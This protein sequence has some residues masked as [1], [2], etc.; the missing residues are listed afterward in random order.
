[1][2]SSSSIEK[3][4][5]NSR[6]AERH[7]SPE[8]NEPDSGTEHEE[9]GHGIE[10]AEL[11]RIAFVALAAAAVWFQLWEPFRHISVIGIAATLIGGFPIFREAGEHRRTKDD[12][13]AVQ[14]A[15]PQP[16][17]RLRISDRYVCMTSCSLMPVIKKNS[18]QSR[19]S[20]S[21][22]AKSVSSSLSSYISGS[23][24][25]YRGQSFLPT[26]PRIPFAF[27]KDMTFE[28]LFQQLRGA[29]S[30]SSRRNAWYFNRSFRSISSRF[31]L[32]QDSV[33]YARAVEYAA[34]VFGFFVSLV[35]SR[36][37]A[38]AAATDL[39]P[40]WPSGTTA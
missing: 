23:S 8:Q 36:K 19:S 33:K 15:L 17:G 9:H 35:S 18:Y 16:S 38:T 12:D 37:S 40:F 26:S 31:S 30:L 21:Q 14:H 32:W 24:S 22:A 3:S 20:A 29:C 6:L 13:G 28:N 1:M 7:G 27:R 25:V 11:V 4:P 10:W 34:S 5:A 39:C 2:S